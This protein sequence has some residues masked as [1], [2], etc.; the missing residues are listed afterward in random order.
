MIYYLFESAI[1]ALFVNIAWRF[2]LY[3]LTDIYINYLQ[4]VVIIW[5]VKMIFF[6]VFK[7]IADLSTLQQL[8]S[9]ETNDL[10]QE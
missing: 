10:K 3:P 2:V 5:I 4:W 8:P 6:D 1:I 7:L 9:V